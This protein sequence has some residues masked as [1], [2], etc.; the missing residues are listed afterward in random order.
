MSSRAAAVRRERTADEHI[1]YTAHVADAIV[2]TRYGDYLQAFRLGGASFESAD[3]E[4]LNTWH[5]RLN[6]LWRNLASPQVALW[7][8]IVRQREHL[9]YRPIG[10]AGFAGALRGKYQARLAQEVL[11]VNE[12]SL[13]IVYRPV[14]GVATSAIGR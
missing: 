2:R 8:H 1:P 7:A 5:E 6:V 11:M 4:Q 10:E 3:D 14:A 12:L 13:T 9:G